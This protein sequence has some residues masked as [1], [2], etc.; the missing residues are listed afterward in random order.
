LSGTTQVQVDILFAEEGIQAN[1]FFLGVD[2]RED[3]S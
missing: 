3:G 1:R 2:H